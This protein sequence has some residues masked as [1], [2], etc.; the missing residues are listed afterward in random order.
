MADEK[1]P[2]RPQA[3]GK[4]PGTARCRALFACDALLHQWGVGTVDEDTLN[5]RFTGEHL[6]VLS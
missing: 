4:A 5:M 2:A 6:N 3:K 1:N